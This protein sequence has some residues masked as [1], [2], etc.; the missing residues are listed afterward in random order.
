MGCYIL[1]DQ[2][3]LPRDRR[4]VAGTGDRRRSR[5]GDGVVHVAET[6]TR[7]VKVV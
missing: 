4:L 7:L 1:L 2:G 5:N 3:L 6:V